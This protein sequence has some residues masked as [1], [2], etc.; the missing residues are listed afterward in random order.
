MA[1]L[2]KTLLRNALKEKE[3]ELQEKAKKA[4]QERK[5]AVKIGTMV[6]KFCKKHKIQNPLEHITNLLNEGKNN[7]C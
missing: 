2:S 3:K 6:V 4:K 1:T 7:G 5:L